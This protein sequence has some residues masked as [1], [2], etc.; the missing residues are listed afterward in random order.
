MVEKVDYNNIYSNAT[1]EYCDWVKQTCIWKADILY[2]FTKNLSVSSVLEIGTGRGDVL[3]AL[4]GFDQKTGADVSEEALKQHRAIYPKHQLVKIDAD[5]KLPFIDKQFDCV[6]LCDILE[7]IEKPVEL[8]KEASRVGKYILVKIPLENALFVRV[9]NKIHGVKYGQ[10]HSSG[11]LYCWDLKDILSL[12][13]KS[14][15]N[16]IDEKFLPIPIDL[17]KK[18]FAVK[19]IVFR[20]CLLLDRISKTNFFNRTLLGGSYFAI[21]Q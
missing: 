16:I 20:L 4:K 10:N 5:E 15:I 7:H 14:Q 2:D 13:K 3:H 1:P 9:M 19:I 11:H 12:L 17:I 6:L 8:L 18:K 21:G